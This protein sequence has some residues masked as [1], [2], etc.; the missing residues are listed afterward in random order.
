MREGRFHGTDETM[1]WFPRSFS[2]Y[3]SL[4]NLSTQ[5]V[6]FEVL[7]IVTTKINVFWGVEP[8]NLDT[9]VF[10]KPTASVYS[11]NRVGR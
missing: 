8:R 9:D 11:S 3:I 4:L 5:N 6:T 10:E 1:L 7:T 2:D